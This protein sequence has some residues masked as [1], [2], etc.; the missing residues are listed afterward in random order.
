MIDH[1]I[2]MVKRK[3]KGTA[4]RSDREQGACDDVSHETGHETRSSTATC[5]GTIKAEYMRSALLNTMT[6]ARQTE[7]GRFR[8]GNHGR[9]TSSTSE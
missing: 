5:I 7:E 3:Q 4:G 1:V 6:P 9:R 2:M 8:K